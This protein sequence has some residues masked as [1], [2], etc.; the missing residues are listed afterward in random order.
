[1]PLVVV[2]PTSGP[3]G[4]GYTL[5]V[6][7]LEGVDSS[8]TWHSVITFVDEANLN[9]LFI[10]DQ[11]ASGALVDD[12]TFLNG[13][14]GY[15][16]QQ[17]GN[18]GITVELL[19]ASGELV[20]A[21]APP[22]GQYQYDGTT[23]LGPYLQNQGGSGG[24]LTPQEH[25]AVLETNALSQAIN[26]ATTAVINLGSSIVQLPI[27]QVLSSNASDTFRIE[28]LGGGVG[29]QPIRVDIS[30]GNYYGVIVRITQYPDTTVFRT[31][32]SGYTFND[33]AVLT[34]VRAGDILTRHGI[35]TVSHTLSPLPETPYPW[36]TNLGVPIQ[37]SDYHVAVDWAPGVCGELLGVVLP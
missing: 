13:Q 1:M 24:G 4:P 35:H 30:L 3:L 19:D 14:L 8:W 2:S 15:G 25:D 36:L 33:L 32:D 9:H 5:R 29:C 31:P 12:L 26:A 37:P 7:R 22:L 20:D 16:F 34:V 27:G 18:L 28:D 17:G 10:F 6:E 11:P 21:V 23:N